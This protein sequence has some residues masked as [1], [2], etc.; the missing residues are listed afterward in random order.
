MQPHQQLK[1][2]LRAWLLRH[3][4]NISFGFIQP[5]RQM[6][7]ANDT[8]SLDVC[9]SWIH[10]VNHHM[11]NSSTN[12]GNFSSIYCINCSEMVYLWCL[13]N[14]C[15]LSGEFWKGNFSHLRL[16]G[17]TEFPVRSI[18]TLRFKQSHNATDIFI[19]KINPNSLNLDLWI[20]IAQPISYGV[21]GVKQLSILKYWSIL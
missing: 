17:V 11:Q 9:L 16:T 3:E 7:Q 18:L 1:Q 21:G 20:H 12:S 8:S 15:C 14:L 6:I 4:Q 13:L 19:D 10:Y 5:Q 2:K